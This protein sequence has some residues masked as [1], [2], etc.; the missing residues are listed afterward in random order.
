MRH[1]PERTCIGCR[2]VV[3]A[4]ELIRLAAPVTIATRRGG[5]AM[6]R[7]GRGAWLH[8][9]LDCVGA[10]VKQRA[11]GRAFRGRVDGLDPVRLLGDMRVALGASA[12]EQGES[13]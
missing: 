12:Q 13:K 11:F 2:R 9:A 5:A 10:A 1:I 7:Q 3:P 6:P 8:P 4:S